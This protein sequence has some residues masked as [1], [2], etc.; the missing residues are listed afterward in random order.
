LFAAQFI[1]AGTLIGR[2]EGTP[3]T[4]DGPYVLWI[5]GEHGFCVENDLK[6]I[7]HAATPN[8]VYYDDLTVE[9]LEDIAPGEEITHHYDG[10]DA[11]F[12]EEPT[13]VA[14]TADAGSSAAAAV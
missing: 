11:D 4:T 3:T 14:F 7:N 5:D 1:P 13:E 9:A 8:A 2:L 10:D 6:Y 12:D